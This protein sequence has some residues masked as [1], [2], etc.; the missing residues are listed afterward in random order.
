MLVSSHDVLQ[1]GW[2]IGPVVTLNAANPSGSAA[3]KSIPDMDVN[4]FQSE[5]TAAPTCLF[6]ISSICDSV[7]AERSTV[8]VA[9]IR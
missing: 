2:F 4:S 7:R 9:I 3:E 6:A 8:S 1:Y 5:L